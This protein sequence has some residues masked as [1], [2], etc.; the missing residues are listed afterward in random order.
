MVCLSFCRNQPRNRVNV[1]QERPLNFKKQKVHYYTEQIIIIQSQFLLLLLTCLYP[2][3][4]KWSFHSSS[5]LH[6]NMKMAVFWVVVPCSLPDDGGS[7]DLWN[8]GKTLPD[9]TVLQPRRQPS[10]YSPPWKPQIL[11]VNTLINPRNYPKVLG[12]K[13]K[14]THYAIFYIS[15]VNWHL[16]SPNI[17]LEDIVQV[18]IFKSN[19]SQVI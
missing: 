13:S 3:L 19:S 12:E 11:H 9:Y 18:L 1:L 2:G 7:K 5:M 15:T 17:L 8:V 6:V 4:L 14:V 10:S 16:L